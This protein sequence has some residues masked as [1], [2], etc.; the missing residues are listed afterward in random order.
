TPGVINTN[1]VD[2]LIRTQ[3]QDTPVLLGSAATFRVGLTGPWKVQWYRNGVAIPGANN[4]IYTTP[5]TTAG[6][7]G[8]RCQAL[9]Q[10][11]DGQQRSDEVMLSIFTPSTTE[12]IGL[13]WV[14]GGANGA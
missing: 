3:P 9:V 8:T 5:T 14:G 1:P 6:E 7:D 12:S 2:N 13:S 11:R 4:A 10:G